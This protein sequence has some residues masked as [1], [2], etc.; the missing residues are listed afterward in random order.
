MPKPRVGESKVYSGTTSHFL[1]TGEL[2][3]ELIS[4]LYA[5]LKF[6]VIPELLLSKEEIL[7]IENP[8]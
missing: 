1:R 6:H 3:I 8:L 7:T 2:S 4:E 5:L